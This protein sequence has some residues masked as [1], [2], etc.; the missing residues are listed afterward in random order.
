MDGAYQSVDAIER[1]TKQG[2]FAPQLF[3]NIAI[4]SLPILRRK[5]APLSSRQGRL[6][7]IGF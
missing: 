2:F 1:V 4:G 7:S 3:T 6:V 5:M